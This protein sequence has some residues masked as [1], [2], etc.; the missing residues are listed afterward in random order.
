VRIVLLGPPGAGKGTQSKLLEERLRIPQISTGD[1]L[2]HAI[3]ERT[4]LGKRAKQFM[5]RGE[6]VPDEVI[7][8]IVDERLHEPDCRNGFLL[9]GFPRTVEQTR[10][11]EGILKKL[12]VDMDG[13]VSL[14]VPRGELLRRLSG[15]RTCTDCGNMYHTVF[16]PP[17]H[18][19]TCDRCGGK[20]VQRPDDHEETI[21][22]RL[23]VYERQTAPIH[24]YF[25]KRGNLRI[26]DGTGSSEEVYQRIL[27]EVRPAA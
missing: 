7:V 3:K 13:A 4:P 22:A 12:G 9:D 11:L 19:S 23:D 16:D 25:A 27:R 6:L 1:M 5:D 2:R 21:A 10:A 18:R 17:R 24:D 20:L 8:G 14:A 15:R 26:I